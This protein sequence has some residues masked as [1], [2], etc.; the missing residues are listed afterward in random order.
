MLTV[1][2]VKY[3][4]CL[5]TSESCFLKC[6]FCRQDSTQL[7][8]SISCCLHT[9]ESMHE[10][11]LLWHLLFANIFITRFRHSVVLSSATC[12]CPLAYISQIFTAHARTIAHYSIVLQYIKQLKLSSMTISQG[13][14]RRRIYL[15]CY[16]LKYMK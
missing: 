12:Y 16:I 15:P 6:T 14:Y 4:H 10:M 13:Y 7:I 9:V 1:Y 8:W 11:F 3:M 5:W 2:N